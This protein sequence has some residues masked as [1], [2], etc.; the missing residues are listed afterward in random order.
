MLADHS[1]KERTNTKGDSGDSRY[2]YQDELDKACFLHNMAY[3]DFKDLPRR[4]VS[5]KVLHDYYVSIII[6]YC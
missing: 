3:G 2:S 6:Y 1:I 4:A 5:D